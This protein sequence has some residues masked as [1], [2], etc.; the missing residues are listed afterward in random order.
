MEYNSQ[1]ENLVIAEYGRNVQNLINYAKTVEDR[2]LRQ[3]YA[4]RIVTLMYQMNPDNRNINN[5]RAKLWSHLLKISDYEIDVDAPEDAIAAPE[6]KI[7]PTPVK[8]PNST[9]TYRHYGY[10]VRQLIEKAL[11]MEDGPKKDSFTQHIARYMKLAYRTWNREHY[12][13]DEIIVEDLKQMS[14]GEL[15]IPNDMDLDISNEFKNNSINNSN[16]NPKTSNL[17]KR[18]TNNKHKNR[19]KKRR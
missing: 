15:N 17:R 12:V 13:S 1:K 14:N 3:K 7:H 4:E 10:Y 18:K 2:E 11:E 8:Y 16:N 5:Y 6:D 9:K 19:N